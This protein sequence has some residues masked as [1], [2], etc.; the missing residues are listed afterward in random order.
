MIMKFSAGMPNMYEIRSHIHAEWN[1]ERP[2]AVGI[3][4][5]R[6]V[7]L[8]MAS[9][10][11]T[12]KALARTKNKI[13][14]SMFR[15]FRWTPD[16]EIGRDS[17]LAAVWVK[18][19]NL[20]L[21]YFNETSLI[22]LGSVLGT[23]L[24]VHHSTRSLTQQKFAKVCVELDV[25]KPL[26]EK[27][28]IGTSKEYGWEI[29]LKYEGNNAYCDYCGLLGHTLGLC[30]KKREDQ[31]KAVAKDGTT[32]VEGITQK[33]NSRPEQWVVKNRDTETFNA[34]NTSHTNMDVRNGDQSKENNVPLVGSILIRDKLQGIPEEIQQKL[35]KTGLI[36]E[37][38]IESSKAK[39]TLENFNNPQGSNAVEA[40]YAGFKENNGSGELQIAEADN[41]GMTKQGNLAF[42]I[43]DNTTPSPT[44]GIHSSKKSSAVAG[45]VE[46]HQN[47]HSGS[48]SN[49]HNTSPLTTNQFSVLDPERELHTA[50]ERLQHSDSA[51]IR[52]KGTILNTSTSTQLPMVAQEESCHL[53]DGTGTQDESNIGV[54]FTK[55]APNSDNEDAHNSRLRKE[56]FSMIP[57]R[58]NTRTS[59]AKLILD[60]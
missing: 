8:H 20:P 12:K 58:R 4:D 38:E 53:S 15:L 14:T 32:R 45:V 11:D 33:K 39:Q 34:K 46:S 48:R 36:S 44:P 41:G 6:H 1:L 51:R 5:Q 27:L 24:G 52:E 13:K 10:A 43:G 50:F 47:S 28:W 21:H 17:S 60:M 7:T 29:S 3:I 25:S 55:S 22:R 30:R 31:G 18:M 49:M 2:P 56:K 23:V 54:R 26:L 59:K 9:P 42:I 16:F 37:E 40:N 35:I 19:S 57:K